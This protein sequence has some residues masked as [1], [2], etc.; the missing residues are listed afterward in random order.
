MLLGL[1]LGILLIFPFFNFEIAE[2]LSIERPQMLALTKGNLDNSNCDR[3]NR[4]LNLL[5][6]VQLGK[7]RHCKKPIQ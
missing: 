2:I 1:S 5:L 7:L 4:F 6:N 3:L